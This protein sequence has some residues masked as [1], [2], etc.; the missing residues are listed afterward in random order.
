MKPNE[1]N[2]SKSSRLK[3][4]IVEVVT[5]PYNVIVLVAII[6]LTY[7]IVFPLVDMLKTTF[8]LSQRDLRNVPGGTAGE[9][10]F[11]YWKRLL[12]SELSMNLLIKP[13]LHSLLIGFGV[14]VGAITL[15]SC[16]AWLMVRSDLPCKPFFSLAVII[17]YMIPSWVKSQAWLSMFIFWASFR[18]SKKLTN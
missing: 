6:L 16:L 10:T 5:N 3:N 2:Y 4:Q 9:F 7:L 8:E 11:Y 12:A 15:G 17:P 18:L 13:L 1:Q 14:S